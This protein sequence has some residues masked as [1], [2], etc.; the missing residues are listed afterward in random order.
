M[1]KRVHVSWFPI[2]T[3]GTNFDQL[4]Y[5]YILDD[6]GLSW[7]FHVTQTVVF[8]RLQ[9]SGPQGADLCQLS[10]CFHNPISIQY[11]RFSKV[12]FNFP[13]KKYLW[14]GLGLFNCNARIV[15]NYSDFKSCYLAPECLSTDAVSSVYFISM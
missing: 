11:I 2:A 13:F 3:V 7:F 1:H 12:L 10:M 6:I 15:H 4:T 5:C 14:E 9:T 8:C